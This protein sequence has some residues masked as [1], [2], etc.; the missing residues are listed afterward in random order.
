MVAE[1]TE[2]KILKSEF[3][4]LCELLADIEFSSGFQRTF[5]KY[6]VE[7]RE[8]I[9]RIERRLGKYREILDGET[10]LMVMYSVLGHRKNIV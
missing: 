8:L 10:D 6:E 1:T 3:L 7:L 2:L 5:E 4:W 9:T